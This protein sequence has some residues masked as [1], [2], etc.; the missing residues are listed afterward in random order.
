M[1]NRNWKCTE[2]EANCGNRI[3]YS[4]IFKVFFYFFFVFLNIYIYI[5]I[6]IYLAVLGLCCCVS[7]SLVAVHGLLTVVASLVAERRL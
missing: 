2:S 7:F 5:Y 1:E 3:Y 4:V 6:Y